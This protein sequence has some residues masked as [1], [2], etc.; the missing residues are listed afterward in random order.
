[1]K[2]RLIVP[3]VQVPGCEDAC[4]GKSC[5]D[6]KHADPVQFY[7]HAIADIA[8][9]FTASQA[10]GGWKDDTGILIVEPVTVFDCAISG[11]LIGNTQWSAIQFRM[12]A[13]RIAKDLRQDC[14]YLE[15]DGVVEYI[16]Q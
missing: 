4:P 6:C 10:T 13:K 15:I 12:L 8:G 16:T 1:M 2:I 11:E 5:Q 14:V 3:N 7:G 9:G